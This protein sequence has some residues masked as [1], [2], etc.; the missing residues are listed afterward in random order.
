L[1]SVHY[2]PT[3]ND[4]A[5]FVETI[6]GKMTPAYRE[7]PNVSLMTMHQAVLNLYSAL[8]F[9]YNLKPTRQECRRIDTL[10]DTLAKEGKLTRGRWRARQRIGVVLLRLMGQAWFT[11]CLTHGCRSWDVAISRFLAISLMTATAGRA[12]DI[13]RSNHYTGLE[14]LRWEH[15]ELILLDSRDK[16]D[17]QQ[18][19]KP[20]MVQDLTARITIAYEKG[21]K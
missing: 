4:I 21:Y 10:L 14:C 20:P 9:K 12:G 18:Q 3:G 2:V 16:D 8:E 11:K 17:G 19:P 13:A 15:I 5:R 1:G 7:K 6:C